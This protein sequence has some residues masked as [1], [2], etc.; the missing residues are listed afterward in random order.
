PSTTLTFTVTSS[1][2]TTLTLSTLAVTTPS[3]STTTV[4]S[5]S[6]S[7]VQYC[8]TPTSCDNQGLQYAAFYNPEGNNA[9]DSYSTFDPTYLKST[10]VGGQGTANLYYSAVTTTAGGID[11][12]C[13]SADIT[14]YGD[15]TEFGCQFFTLDHRGYLF[16]AE[17]GTYTFS[18]SGVDDIF[19][20]WTG[21]TAQSG[22]TRDNT[23]LTVT[24]T[25]SDGSYSVDLTQGEYL[26]FRMIFGQA[27][28]YAVFQVSVTDPNNDVILDSD[29]AG[30][31]YLVQYSCDGTTAPQF[32]GAFGEE[33]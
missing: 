17:T 6:T 1:P 26:P 27:Q 23:A 7:T 31:P 29:S 3:A 11:N 16:A 5:T 32:A 20:L 8:P 21:T 25:A 13:T 19:F 2:T 10:S 15:S 12:H 30:S 9:D 4:I 24:E 28:G 18:V 14:V 22:W 33:E